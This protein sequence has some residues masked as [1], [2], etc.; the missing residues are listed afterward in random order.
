MHSEHKNPTKSL[1]VIYSGRVQGVG[2]R[3]TTK[4]IASRYAVEG[5]VRNLSDGTVELRVQGASDQVD[6]FLNEIHGESGRFTGNITE[7]TS[8]P[9]D[10]D[11]GFSGFSQRR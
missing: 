4:R 5:Y 8:D 10:F 2:F 6:S 7:F 1:R 3:W 11:D 9:V